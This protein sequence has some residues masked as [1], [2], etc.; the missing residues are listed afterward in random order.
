MNKLKFQLQAEIDAAF[1]YEQLAINKQ[2]SP[3]GDIFHK[4][5]L[6]ENQHAEKVLAKIHKTH[7]NFKA[8]KPSIRARLQVKIANYFG[9]DFILSHLAAEEWRVSE[10]VVQG[11]REKGE[12]ITGHE[13]LHFNIIQQLAKKDNVSIGGNLLSRFE[14]KH[15]NIGGNELRAA[16]LG[17]NDGLVSNMSLV[18]G[19]AG[20]ASGQ[21]AVIV[22]GV[23]GLLA[24]SISMALGE[25]LSVQSS[26]E[27]YQRQIDIEAQE[28]E[29]SPE[30]EMKELALLYQAKGMKESDAMKLAKD[31]LADKETALDTLVR[32]ELGIDMEHLGGSAWKAAFASFFLFAFGAFIP[33]CPFFFLQNTQAILG[34]MVFSTIALFLMGAFI[35]IFT[36][37]NALYS[38]T[39]QVIFGLTA[40][41]ITYGIGKLIGVS[42]PL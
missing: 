21:P 19:V 1:L 37:K 20:A 28:L 17:A 18:T 35:T 40:A 29:E 8:P 16:V 32:E 4:M 25:W 42:I 10:A 24:G 33:L 2:G 38:G 3:S 30:E 15:K 7:P 27:L 14:G 13:N 22:A 26:R 11:K 31:M 12:T 9:F 5:S 23:A 41:A 34:S 36:G 6:I 39:R